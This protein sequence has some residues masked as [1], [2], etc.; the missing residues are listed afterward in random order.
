MTYPA[1]PPGGNET[2]VRPDAG[3]FWAGVAATA[4]VAALIALVGILICRW[5][6]NI[7]ILAPSG[8]GAWGNAHT[9]EYVFGAAGAA[10]VGG[11]L[12]YLLMLATPQPGLFFGWIIGLATLAGVVYPFS[13]GAPLEQKAATAIVNLVLGIAIGTLLTGVAARAVRREVRPAV[14]ERYDR[15]PYNRDAYNRDASDRDAYNRDP[16]NRGRYSTPTEPMDYPPSRS[17]GD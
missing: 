6:L 8:D 9:S 2:R 14:P 13:T 17:R 16:Y 3:R 4:V 1:P 12:M 15:D 5:T 11:A 7:P 10:I